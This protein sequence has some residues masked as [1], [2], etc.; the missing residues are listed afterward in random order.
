MSRTF[1]ISLL[2]KRKQ[3]HVAF[4]VVL[5]FFYLLGY[6]GK[7]YPLSYVAANYFGV[8]VLYAVIIYST[9]YLVFSRFV[10]R[11]KYVAG[12]LLFTAILLVCT[13]SN[14]V[15]YNVTNAEGKIISLQNFLPFYLFLAAFA[16]SLKIARKS[17]LELH[18]EILLKEDLLRQKEY[19][20]RSQIHPHFLFNTLNNFYALALEKSDLLPDLMIRLSNI[21]RHQIYQ[22]ELSLISLD[23][24]IEYLKDYIELEKIRYGKNLNF[25]FEFPKNPAAG[26]FIPPSILIVFFENAFKHSYNIATENIDI[27]GH[28]YMENGQLKFFLKNSIPESYLKTKGPAGLGLQN[29]RKRL[30]LTGDSN[31]LLRTEEKDKHYFVWLELK[32]AGNEKV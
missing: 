1:V 29:V 6:L 19:F 23:K 7:P 10:L 26:Y 8:L 30:S 3:L 14:A 18:R 15:L 9:L 22:S 27:S 12:A 4:W 20:L 25:Q 24:E 11:R 5:A 32:L 21:L 31:Y 2:Q 17:Y 13:H 28:L 16:L